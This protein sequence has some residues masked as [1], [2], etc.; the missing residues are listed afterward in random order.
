MNSTQRY[1]TLKGLFLVGF[2]RI[3]IGKNFIHVDDD[4][5]KAMKVV[6]LYDKK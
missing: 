3:G 5:E 6:W 2:S 1:A 4:S